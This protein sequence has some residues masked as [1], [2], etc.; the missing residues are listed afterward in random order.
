MGPGMGGADTGTG[1]LTEFLISHATNETWIL[2]VPSAQE[3]ANLI[4]G[5][6]SRSCAWA[7]LPAA[8]R[9]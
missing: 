7:G 3:G 9:S 2:A 1:K 4:I 5:P 8:T 6:E